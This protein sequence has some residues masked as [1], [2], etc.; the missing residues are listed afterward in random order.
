[1][2]PA[3]DLVVVH[4]VDSDIAMGPL[5]GQRKPEP[6]FRQIARLLWLILS[7]A[8]DGEVGPDASLAHATGK[9]LDGE[10]L[11][12]ALSGTTLAVLRML[13]GGPYT[14]QLR[15]DGIPFAT[16]RTRAPRALQGYM[17]SRRRSL[18]SNAQRS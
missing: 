18:L 1:V 17:A 7:S 4:R 10:S 6:T 5:P 11:R 3:Y 8:G 16:R 13:A 9:R 15:A 2:I 12:A 14:L